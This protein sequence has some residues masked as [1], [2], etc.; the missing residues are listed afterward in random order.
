MNCDIIETEIVELLGALH[1]EPSD[2]QGLR[3]C[4]ADVILRALP[5]LERR[6]TY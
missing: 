6:G 1:D 5:D 3:K 4:I 2:M